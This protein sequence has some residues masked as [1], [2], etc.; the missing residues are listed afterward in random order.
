M[1][2]IKFFNTASAILLALFVGAMSFTCG[3]SDNKTEGNEVPAK[4]DTTE[5]VSTENDSNSVE[6]TDAT[7]QPAGT[8]ATEG[9]DK[10]VAPEANEQTEKADAPE[11][12]EATENAGTEAATEVSK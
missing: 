5:V 11:T 10:A 2:K 9:Q 1:R 6:A 12:A 7:Q 8:E 4:T 3:Q